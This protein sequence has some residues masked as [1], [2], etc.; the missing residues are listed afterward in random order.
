MRGSLGCSQEAGEA[1]RG[2]ECDVDQKEVF[3]KTTLQ[4]YGRGEIGD[5][6]QYSPP[7]HDGAFLSAS[8]WMSGHTPESL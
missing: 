1:I 3:R 8:S 5:L 2:F 4:A 6:V 7:S